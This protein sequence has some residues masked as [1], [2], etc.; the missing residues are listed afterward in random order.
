MSSSFS[1][2]GDRAW[3]KIETVPNNNNNLKVS[4]LFMKDDGVFPNNQDH[5]VLLFQDAFHETRRDAEQLIVQNGWTAPWAWGIFSFHHYHSTAWE[6]LVCVRGQATV[7]LGGETGPSDVVIS[8]GDVVLIPPGFAHK[9]LSSTGGFTLLGSYPLEGC[10]GPVDTLRG[11]PTE[12][13]RR[14]IATCAV[15]PRD[16]I[17]DVELSKLY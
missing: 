1:D 16:P 2:N 12:Q 14:N 17:F 10:S 8:K 9:Q 11:A 3:G 6:L 7:Q 13:E 15:P 4:R 5:P